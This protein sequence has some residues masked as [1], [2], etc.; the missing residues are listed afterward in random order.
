ML[1]DVGE[2]L[3]RN[4]VESELDRRRERTPFI[5]ANH[6][7]LDVVVL[8]DERFEGG[9]QR[10][11]VER[12]FAE[13]EHGAACVLQG[14]ARQRQSRAATLSIPRGRPPTDSGTLA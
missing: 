10:A 4:A 12:G 9:G 2:G 6:R 11:S 13:L 1:R 8:G 7:E 5:E 3:L 14:G